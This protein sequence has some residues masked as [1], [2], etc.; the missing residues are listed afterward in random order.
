MLLLLV[1]LLMLLRLLTLS[2]LPLLQAAL[3]LDRDYVLY[4]WRAQFAR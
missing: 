2:A 3:L 4:V 1:L